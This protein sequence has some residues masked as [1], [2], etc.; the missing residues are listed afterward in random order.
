M[1]RLGTLMQSPRL[2]A[3]HAFALVGVIVVGAAALYILYLALEIHVLPGRPLTR[4]GANAKLRGAGSW[5]LVT[6]ATDGI[7]REFA[8][9]LAKGGFNIVLVSRTVE[10]LATLGREIETKYPGT[11]TC[12]YAMDFLRAGAPEYEGLAQLIH[13]LDVAVLVNNVG[14]S[15][16]MPVPFIEM[17][18]AE[19][20]AI[21]EVN[22]SGTQRV[23]RLIGPKLVKR[24]VL[25]EPIDTAVAA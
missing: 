9:Q 13:H 19:M 20:E 18:E 23:T 21:I 10:K 11:K 2:L 8:M 24:C 15:H 17:D 5:A 3:L 16:T 25:L 14:V 1:D 12:F 7:G 22:V 4:Y 6:G